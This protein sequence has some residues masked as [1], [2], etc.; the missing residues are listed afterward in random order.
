METKTEVIVED[1]EMEDGSIFV[2]FMC[3]Q[4]FSKV[5][6][7]NSH[8]Q[9]HKNMPEM[10][11]EFPSR[12]RGR[13][14]GQGSGSGGG[15]GGGGGG[16]RPRGR[17]RGRGQGRGTA[18][19]IQIDLDDPKDD[20]VYIKQEIVERN[21]KKDGCGYMKQDVDNNRVKKEEVV[22]IKQETDSSCVKKAQRIRQYFQSRLLSSGRGSEKKAITFDDGD[23]DFSEGG[24][25]IPLAEDEIMMVPQPSKKM[26]PVKTLPSA[27]IVSTEPKV[28]HT[29]SAS[30]APSTNKKVKLRK[31]LIVQEVVYE[32]V[33]DD[34]DGEEIVKTVSSVPISMATPTTTAAS[35]VI[36]EK[37]QSKVLLDPD[38]EEEEEEDEEEGDIIEVFDFPSNV[39]GK[40]GKKPG[41][42]SQPRGADDGP[43]IPCEECG[44]EFRSVTTLRVH[45]RA[46]REVKEFPCP[47]CDEVF[48]QRHVLHQHLVNDHEESNNLTCSICGKVFTRT[49]SLK[50]HMVRMHEEDGGLNCYICGKN[51]PSQGQLE[52]HVRVHTGERPFKCDYCHKGFIQKVHLRTHLRTMHN[53]HEIQS[54]PCR[55]C[56]AML[57]GR[58]GLRDHYSSVHGLTNNQYKSRVAK[59]RK[60]GKIPELPPPV[61][62][63][64]DPSL[65]YY[66]VSVSELTSAT[67][68]TTTVASP[69]K[70]V[71]KRTGGTRGRPPRK[72]PKVVDSDSSSVETTTYCDADSTYGATEVKFEVD[73]DAPK[74]RDQE[75]LNIVES[76]FKVAEQM[77]QLGANVPGSTTILVAGQ[78]SATTGVY[79]AIPVV[80]ENNTSSTTT[81]TTTSN[82]IQSAPTS[83]NQEVASQEAVTATVTSTVTANGTPMISTTTS[84]AS[85]LQPVQFGQ[86]E[87]D[88]EYA[89]FAAEHSHMES[90]G[91][92]S[93]ELNN[94]GSIVRAEPLQLFTDP[95]D[96]LQS[97]SV[98][99]FTM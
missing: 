51:F 57:D 79:Y 42:R 43:G 91:F 46:H 92:Q 93:E 4:E 9:T 17:G 82:I 49:D 90:E 98:E 55:I 50:S 36:K 23:D 40:E 10:T 30:G 21:P 52:M 22:Y 64:V 48:P 67:S 63:E 70:T 6:L 15:G 84:D 72:V 76:A 20:T 56:N 78:D 65:N 85:S 96:P 29:P 14:R 26:M 59:L 34:E 97:E 73:G 69:K 99:M 37:P 58:A 28:F 39:G 81:T 68:S 2:C 5:S 45:M 80:M 11:K 89:Q 31:K 62:K 27:M 1:D 38:D 19:P 66:K 54:T 44:K 12:R 53:M 25:G 3:E 74:R 88:E 71:V 87:I 60:E 75:E 16:G 7:L 61:V 83:S 24:L 77:D 86:E 41:R 35:V 47:Y 13:G 94:K 33:E 8:M 32:E 95:N 18:L